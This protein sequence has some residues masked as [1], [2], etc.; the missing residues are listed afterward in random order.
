M[1]K[2]KNKKCNHDLGVGKAKYSPGLENV[3]LEQMLK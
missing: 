3:D 1:N 2:T